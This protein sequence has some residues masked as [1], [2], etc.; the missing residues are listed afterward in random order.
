MGEVDMFDD[1]RPAKPLI[2][3][4]GADLST[5]SIA[6]LRERIALLRAEMERIEAELATKDTSRNAAESLFSRK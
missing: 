1:D 6:E 4:I 2:H 3:E 5:L